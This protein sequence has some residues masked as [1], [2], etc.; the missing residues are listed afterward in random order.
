MFVR[1]RPTEGSKGAAQEDGWVAGEALD[2]EEKMQGPGESPGNHREVIKDIAF[3]ASVPLGQG[4]AQEVSLGSSSSC[5]HGPTAAEGSSGRKQKLWES[6][7]ESHLLPGQGWLSWLS[8]F[9]HSVP[10]CRIPFL[11]PALS[12]LSSVTF[13]T[14]FTSGM[15]GVSFVLG[16]SV[17]L[18]SFSCLRAEGKKS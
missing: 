6:H 16:Q 1:G 9:T 12:Q 10:L 4:G 15:L 14:I 11:L 2:E 17:D 13:Q 18:L 3:H 7:N 5:L 8:R